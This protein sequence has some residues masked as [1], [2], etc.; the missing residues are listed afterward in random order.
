MVTLTVSRDSG[1]VDNLRAYHILLDGK[2][3]GKL[4]NGETREFTVDPGSH[5]IKAKIDWCSSQTL[6]FTATDGEPLVFHVKSNLRGMRLSLIFWK[7]L[8]APDSYLH[9]ERISG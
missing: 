3:I 6:D 8:F 9:L 1:Y 7:V 2:K 4:K 5:S